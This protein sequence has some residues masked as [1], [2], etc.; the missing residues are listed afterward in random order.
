MSNSENKPI[1]LAS[2]RQAGFVVTYWKHFGCSENTFGPY[3]MQYYQ[4]II[5]ILLP[6]FR[7]TVLDKKTMIPNN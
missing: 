3:T 2:S 4:D 6:G 1:M 5:K 7:I